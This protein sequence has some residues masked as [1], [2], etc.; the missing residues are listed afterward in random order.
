LSLEQINTINEAL[1]RYD[2]HHTQRILL[3][4]DKVKEFLKISPSLNN[5]RFLQTLVRDYQ[6]YALEE[7]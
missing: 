4:A 2:D 1:M 7:V 6:Y 5:E 3:L